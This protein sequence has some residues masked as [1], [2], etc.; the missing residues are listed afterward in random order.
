MNAVLQLIL[1]IRLCQ[2]AAAALSRDQT[3]LGIS[4]KAAVDVESQRTTAPGHQARCPKEP[5]FAVAAEVGHPGS[6]AGLLDA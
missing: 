6:P 3:R 2:R 1:R 5:A 4:A